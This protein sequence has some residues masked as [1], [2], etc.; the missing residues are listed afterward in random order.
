MLTLKRFSKGQWF[1]FPGVEGVRF[2]IRP[3][4]LSD[5]ISVRSKIRKGVAVEI[6]NPQKEGKTLSIMMEDVDQ[7][8]LT[9]KVFDF[10]LQDFEGL[11][12]EDDGGKII[13]LEPGMAQEETVKIKA[14]I[15][16][17]AFD[18][19]EIRDFVAEKSEFLRTANEQKKES[20]MGNSESSQSG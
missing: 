19:E 20:E 15:K 10:M 2:L 4:Q 1:D 11:Q 14:E 3:F 9:Y 5:G 18:S 17:A 6:P 13:K 8:E 12:I 7:G 16:R